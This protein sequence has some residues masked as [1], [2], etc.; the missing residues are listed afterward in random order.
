MTILAPHFCTQQ[1]VTLNDTNPSKY[2]SFGLQPVTNYNGSEIIE[3]INLKYG[4][5]AACR[6]N[7]FLPRMRYFPE[8]QG[9]GQQRGINPNLFVF[10]PNSQQKCLKWVRLISCTKGNRHSAHNLTKVE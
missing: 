9:K 10:G 2:L 7:F 1:T 6:D 3:L 5:R 8:K 4:K